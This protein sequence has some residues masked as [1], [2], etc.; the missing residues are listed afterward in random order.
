MN[1]IWLPQ[2]DSLKAWFYA[3][4]HP[5]EDME[6]RSSMRIWTYCPYCGRKLECS[7]ANP[8]GESK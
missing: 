3:K 2:N 8:Q 5:D 6:Q 4:D 1:C 7:T